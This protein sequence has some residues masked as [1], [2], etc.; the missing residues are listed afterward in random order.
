MV[1]LEEYGWTGPRTQTLLRERAW[2]AQL[3]PYRF[4]AV[5]LRALPPPIV[6]VFSCQCEPVRAVCA[7]VR[8]GGRALQ[9]VSVTSSDTRTQGGEAVQFSTCASWTPDTAGC[10]SYWRLAF[11]RDSFS[12]RPL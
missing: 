5:R 6:V 4:G 12:S 7:G 8:V 10:G 1:K 2:M 3:G 11:T 9:S